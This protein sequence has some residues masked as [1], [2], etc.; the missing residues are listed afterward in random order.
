MGNKFVDGNVNVQGRVKTVVRGPK[1]EL[2]YSADEHNDAVDLV[3]N[4]LANAIVAGTLPKISDMMTT[5]VASGAAWN[6]SDGV[7]IMSEDATN[8]NATLLAGAITAATSTNVLSVTASNS[9]FNTGT[10]SRFC[11]GHDFSTALGIGAI[12]FEHEPGSFAYS[13]GDTIT[14]NWTVSVT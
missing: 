8:S 2:K 11:L 3:K 5:G 1:G 10:M 7:F 6:G 13:S 12:Y 4:V 9:L 14:V